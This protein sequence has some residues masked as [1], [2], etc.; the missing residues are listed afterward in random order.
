MTISLLTTLALSLASPQGQASGPPR[1]IT[2]QNIVPFAREEWLRAV[3]PFAPGEVEELPSLHVEGTPTVWQPIGARHLDGSLRQALCLFRAKLDAGATRTLE[4][5]PG[6]GPPLPPAKF[7]LAPHQL[8]LVVVQDGVET[9]A[10][11][12]LTELLEDNAARKV[13]LM[14]C[15]LGETGL[16]AE[17]T[18]QVYAGQEH[19]YMGLGV[20][21]S[22]PTTSCSTFVRLPAKYREGVCLVT[23][24]TCYSRDVDFNASIYLCGQSENC[25]RMI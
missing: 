10:V 18:I 21:Y 6:A 12:E 22:D 15:R 14:R 20:F 1:V 19:A 25:P 17:V 23:A 8:R 7:D 4:L 13:A 2:A 24:E 3:V 11:P 9:R 5:V 16:V